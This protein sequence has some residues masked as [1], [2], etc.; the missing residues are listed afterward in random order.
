MSETVLATA[1]SDPAAKPAAPSA[2]ISLFEGDEAWKNSLPDDLKADQTVRNVKTIPDVVKM[3]LH[4]QKTIGADKIVVPGKHATDEDY[5]KIF[6][7]LGRPAAPDK[8]E[9][10]IKEGA[11]PK[12]L[13]EG[14]KTAIHGAGLLPS[15][16]Q[17]VF[18]WMQAESDKANEASLAS[19]KAATEKVTEDLKKELGQAYL[20]KMVAAE[21]ALKNVIGD[22]A[23][24]KEIIEDP[25]LG[26]HPK[27]LKLALKL[28]ELMKEDS[29][30]SEGRPDGAMTPEGAR[31]RANE[32][33]MDAK[34][35]F[36]DGTHPNH[37]LAVQEMQKLF[38]MAQG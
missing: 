22:D 29:D 8:Y 30:G 4:A 3:M 36:M 35:P 14:F 28:G 11:A 17:K 27:F 23:L 12:E 18:D 13:I 5:A 37:A 16:A 7:K 19:Q 15:Q 26:N 20:P 10:K 6:D 2:A 31:K 24:A 21:A 9:L 33:M 38:E 32:I 25:V 34:S 1:A